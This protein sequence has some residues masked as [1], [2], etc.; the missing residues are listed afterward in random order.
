MAVSRAL[1]YM[2]EPCFLTPALPS[3]TVSLLAS[4]SSVT[5]LHFLPR[6]PAALGPEAS[7]RVVI[8]VMLV[9]VEA[10]RGMAPAEACISS[11]SFCLRKMAEVRFLEST[12]RVDSSSRSRSARTSAQW[13]LSSG[14][15][16]MSHLLVLSPSYCCTVIR[17]K[18]LRPVIFKCCR[19]HSS[20]SATGVLDKMCTELPEET[21]T[22]MVSRISAISPA[23]GHP[24]TSTVLGPSAAGPKRSWPSLLTRDSARY[25]PFDSSGATVA[26]EVALGRGTTQRFAAAAWGATSTKTSCACRQ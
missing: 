26:A 13:A 4:R 8:T 15:L 19:I 2:K 16:V 6:D 1:V 9:A 18:L 5:I 7:V 12:A 10:E 17:L 25:S 20:R 24:S 23:P 3:S 14:N 21:W 11:S 22:S